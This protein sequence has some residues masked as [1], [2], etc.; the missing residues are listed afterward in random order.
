VKRV[1]ECAAAGFAKRK[2]AIEQALHATTR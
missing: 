2:A 1:T